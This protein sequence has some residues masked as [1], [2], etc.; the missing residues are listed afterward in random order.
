MTVLKHKKC[1]GTLV[2]DASSA[3]ALVTP[4]FS[5]R[6][7]GEFVLGITELKERKAAKFADIFQCSKCSVTMSPESDEILSTCNVCR[8][9]KPASQMFV[10][11]AISQICQKCADLL[12]DPKSETDDA[13]VI[14]YRQYLNLPEK[15]VTVPMVN[16]MKSKFA[17]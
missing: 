8:K 7:S 17:I 11:S 3:I 9:D 12:S 10:S 14:E 2:V 1:G 15:L 4:S 5:F 6:A 16:I 13:K